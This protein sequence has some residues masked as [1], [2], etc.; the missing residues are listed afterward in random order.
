[1][2]VVLALLVFLLVPESPRWIAD[3]AARL[4]GDHPALIRS[5]VLEVFR[6]PL[7]WLTLIGI[8]LGTVPLIGGWGSANWAVF[9]ADQVGGQDDPWLKGYTQLWR[10][11]GSVP[12]SLLA[13]WL[14]TL[15]G[16][17]RCYLLISLGSLVAAQYLFRLSSPGY[18][19]FMVLVVVLGVFNGLYFGWLPLFLPELFPTHARSTGAGVSYNFGRI[20]TAVAVLATGALISHFGGRYGQIGTITSFIFAVGMFVILLAPDTSSK[21]LED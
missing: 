6:P 17:R 5:P 15:V 14:A 9:W 4:R 2:P 3:R 13:G 7:I 11:I 1:V 21:Q 10:S 12:G 18:G 20:L 8:V 16:R 19:Q